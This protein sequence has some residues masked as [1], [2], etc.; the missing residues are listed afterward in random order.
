MI[1]RLK[2]FWKA[3]PVATTLL[4]VALACVLLFAVRI[5][6]HAERWNDPALQEQPIAAW[7][8]PGYIGHVYHI[9]RDTVIE[10]LEA[11][12]PPPDGPMTLAEL[13][14]Y[15]GVS[16]ETVLDEARALVAQAAAGGA[17]D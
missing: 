17:D 15:R 6:I 9:P 13:A 8:T 7:M 12:F 10:A 3:A 4:A 16:V 1:A 11:P 14:A 5:V 2:R